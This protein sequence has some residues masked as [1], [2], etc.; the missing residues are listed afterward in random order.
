M[1]VN[2]NKLAWRRRDVAAVAAL[3]VGVVASVIAALLLAPRILPVTSVRLALF[4]AFALALAALVQVARGA[5]AGSEA[6]LLPVGPVARKTVSSSQRASERDGR[7]TSAVPPVDEERDARAGRAAPAGSAE[8][9]TAGA[10]E[11]GPALAAESADPSEATRK[12]EQALDSIRERKEK[13]ARIRAEAEQTLSRIDARADETGTV[14]EL[15]AATD[16]DASEEPVPQEETAAT[17]ASAGISPGP[18]VDPAIAAMRTQMDAM[19][20]ELETMRMEV[21]RALTA[22]AATVPVHAAPVA[23]SVAGA[24]RATTTSRRRRRKRGVE[25]A[26]P[27]DGR[28]ETCEI[29]WWHGARKGGFEARATKPTGRAYLAGRSP[30]VRWESGDPPAQAGSIAAAHES[31]VAK[32][33]REGWEPE[34]R[35]DTWYGRRF[36]RRSEASEPVEVVESEEPPQKR[37]GR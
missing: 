17:P 20:T 6:S 36:R 37:R 8:A 3:F 23:E 10:T 7:K 19:R 21:E 18:D 31:L 27:D 11:P 12:A 15:E 14:S 9:A 4:V 29:A 13:L 33:V 5:R 28:W 30:M 26:P 22:T 35:G 2:G 32:L 25:Q 1:A 24:S 16:D 34:G